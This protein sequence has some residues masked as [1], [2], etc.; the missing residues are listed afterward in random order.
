MYMYIICN[1]NNRNLSVT[2]FF[3]DFLVVNT[4]AFFDQNFLTTMALFLCKKAGKDRVLVFS[5]VISKGVLEVDGSFIKHCC[6]CS[7]SF[8]TK[9][10]NIFKLKL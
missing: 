9:S 7:K 6:S 4:I 10:R 3:S 8:C 5:F 2:I 1:F